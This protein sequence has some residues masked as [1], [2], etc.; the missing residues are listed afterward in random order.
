MSVRHVQ[1]NYY[2]YKWSL[3][4]WLGQPNALT[5]KSRLC[6]KIFVMID[7]CSYIYVTLK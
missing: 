5:D 7:T 3:A 6:D 2:L 1:T 4:R